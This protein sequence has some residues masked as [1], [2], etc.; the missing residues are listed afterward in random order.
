MNWN[1]GSLI[2]KGKTIIGKIWTKLG[3]QK[4]HLFPLQERNTCL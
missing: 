1:I 3:V 2:G 4:G